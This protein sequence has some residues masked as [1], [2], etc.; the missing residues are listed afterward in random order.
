MIIHRWYIWR[1]NSAELIHNEE[2]LSDELSLWKCRY[3]ACNVSE[4][5]NFAF[6]FQIVLGS[7]EGVETPKLDVSFVF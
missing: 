1:Y 2:C 7:V 5:V 3:V 6:F 4:D